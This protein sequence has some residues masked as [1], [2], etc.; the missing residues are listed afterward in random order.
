MKMRPAFLALLLAGLATALTP[1]E[2]LDE[3]TDSIV[4]EGGP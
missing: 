3:E 2:F 4:V 1:D